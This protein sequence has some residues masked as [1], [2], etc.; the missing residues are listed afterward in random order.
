MLKII[1]ICGRLDFWNFSNKRK[2]EMYVISN[3][4]TFKYYT[5]RNL[6]L[7][8]NYCSI[9]TF[10]CDRSQT[11]LCDGF[12]RILWKVSKE[13]DISFT[14]HFNGWKINGKTNYLLTKSLLYFNDLI[15]YILIQQPIKY[16]WFNNG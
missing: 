2:N 10:Q 4:T 9:C 12:K 5:Y 13:L 3:L 1:R 6:L 14:V 15:K 7:S 16:C 11:S 8:C